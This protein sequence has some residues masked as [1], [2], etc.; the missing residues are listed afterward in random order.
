M[1]ATEI[2]EEGRPIWL[3]FSSG[4]GGIEGERGGSD[5][6][7]LVFPL[8]YYKFFKKAKSSGGVERASPFVDPINGEAERLS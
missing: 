8:F 4:L 1:G 2:R 6:A 3:E 5:W 7:F